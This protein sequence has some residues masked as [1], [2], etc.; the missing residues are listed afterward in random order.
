MEQDPISCHVMN[1]MI[2][3]PQVTTNHPQATSFAGNC[4]LPGF[5]TQNVGMLHWASWATSTTLMEYVVFAYI[6]FLC[7]Q[8][9]AGFSEELQMRSLQK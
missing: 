4:T 7:R 2:L 9:Y 3:Y 6:D 1:L 5:C 8:S